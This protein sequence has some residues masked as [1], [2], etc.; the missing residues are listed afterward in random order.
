MRKIHHGDKILA[1]FKALG[2]GIVQLAY[3]T[4]NLVG[5]GCYESHDGGLSDPA[6]G[7]GAMR[8]GQPSTD[9]N[10]LGTVSVGLTL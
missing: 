7:P 9:F 1:L 4:Q 3:N 10:A 8:T 2:V 5:T 6:A